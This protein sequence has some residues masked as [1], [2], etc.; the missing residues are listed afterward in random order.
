VTIRLSS[1]QIPGGLSD[2]IPPDLFDPKLVEQGRKVER[3]H[4]SSD[5]MAKEIARDHLTEDPRYYSKLKRVESAKGPKPCP[6][7]GEENEPDENGQYFCTCGENYMGQKVQADSLDTAPF[8]IDLS[9]Q[10]DP[11]TPETRNDT[12]HANE[13]MISTNMKLT[14]ASRRFHY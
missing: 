3:E 4:T 12:Q 13:N 10:D 14:A 5:P 2:D 8:Q 6:A 9:E 11:F 1:D 7:C